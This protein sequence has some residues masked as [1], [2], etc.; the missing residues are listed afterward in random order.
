MEYV[1]LCARLGQRF[2]EQMFFSEADARDFCA[3]RKEKWAIGKVPF[4]LERFKA[5][6]NARR[7]R[8]GS[9]V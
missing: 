6:L 4:P 5:A 7:K 9:A 8:L 1:W 2:P 3:G